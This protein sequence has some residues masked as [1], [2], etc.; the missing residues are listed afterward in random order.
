MLNFEKF[1]SFQNGMPWQ[2]T[3]QLTSQLFV[4]FRKRRFE[5]Y[6]SNIVFQEERVRNKIFFQIVFHVCFFQNRILSKMGWKSTMLISSR[7]EAIKLKVSLAPSICLM[8]SA[9]LTNQTNSTIIVFQLYMNW[10]QMLRRF[11]KIFRRAFKRVTVMVFH[12]KLYSE[13]QNSRW[14]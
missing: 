2:L 6:I 1:C 5:K 3:G 8:T 10:N 7:W 12:C 14:H 9:S 11:R 4:L 13:L